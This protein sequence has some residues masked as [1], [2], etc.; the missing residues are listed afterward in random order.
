MWIEHEDTIYNLNRFSQILK[1]GD[2]VI[3]LMALNHNQDWKHEEE[4]EICVLKFHCHEDREVAWKIL[5]V[6]LKIRV[7]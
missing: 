2:Q 7:I 1:G 3:Y 6:K 4:N 5:Q